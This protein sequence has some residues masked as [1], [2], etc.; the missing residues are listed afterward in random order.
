M[1]K[2]SIA[3]NI[4]AGKL[5][6]ANLVTRKTAIEAVNTSSSEISTFVF[7]KDYQRANQHYSYLAKN[8]VY[9]DLNW[10]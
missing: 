4:F 1:K 2:F 10:Q 5:I 6:D 3:T 9:T 8:I 7:T